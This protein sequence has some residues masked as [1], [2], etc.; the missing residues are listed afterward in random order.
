ML[1][2]FEQRISIIEKFVQARGAQEKDPD[3]MVNMCEDLLREPLLEEAIRAGDCLAML[4]EHYHGRGKMREAYACIREFENRNIAPHPFVHA[5]MLNAIYSALPGRIPPRLVVPALAVA[6][7]E[8]PAKARPLMTTM[9][10][11]VVV[12]LLAPSTAAALQTMRS[13]TR[14]GRN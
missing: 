12:V 9:E 6:V 3:A 8:G 13:K 4:T 1:A 2:R 7:A 10:V 14:S 11:V 5:E